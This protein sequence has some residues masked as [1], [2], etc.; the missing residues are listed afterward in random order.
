M[1]RHSIPERPRSRDELEAWYAAAL[2]DQA[3]SGLSV[4]EYAEGI[5]VTAATLYQWRRR[6]GADGDD[7]KNSAQ[8]AGLVEVTLEA[9]P[10]MDLTGTFTVHLGRDRSIELPS[11]FDDNDLRRLINV[12]ESC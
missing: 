8:P 7:R 5:G 4:A 2:D 10:S 12:L 11:Q 6:F 1:P 9:N 3:T